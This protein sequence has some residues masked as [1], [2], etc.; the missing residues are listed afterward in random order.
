MN[1]CIFA[2]CFF[3]FCFTCCGFFSGMDYSTFSFTLLGLTSS[4]FPNERVLSRIELPR[5]ES[6]FFAPL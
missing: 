5:K 3:L 4:P 2:S 1:S 6:F